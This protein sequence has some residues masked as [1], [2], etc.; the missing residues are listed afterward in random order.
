MFGRCV[1]DEGYV[2][3]EGL[4][5]PASEC[6]L[7]TNPDG[8]RLAMGNT[9]VDRTGGVGQCETY[10]C[11][12]NSQLELSSEG[13]DCDFYRNRC[14]LW[15]YDETTTNSDD[16]CCGDC[17]N[18]SAMDSNGYIDL[19]LNLSGNSNFEDDDE[20]D[21]EDDTSSSMSGFLNPFRLGR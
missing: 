3:Y 8:T 14:V 12:E 2:R 5:I 9:Y 6:P 15:P 17:R 20:D 18:D 21:D 13:Y 1:C 4:C 11:R 10:V 7:C 19:G 16:S